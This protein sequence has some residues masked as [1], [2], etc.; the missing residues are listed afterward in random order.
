M[1]VLLAVPA[2]GCRHLQQ[3]L[4]QRWG[5]CRRSSCCWCWC[6]CRWRPLPLLLGCGGARLL[7]L[8]PLLPLLPLPLLLLWLAALPAAR[9]GP[10]AGARLAWGCAALALAWGCAALAWGCCGGH[11]YRYRCSHS[12]LPAVPP[13]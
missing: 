10:L 2:L 12:K 5:G 3:R 7:V 8:L 6:C 9:G 1:V 13:W 11:R 4:L